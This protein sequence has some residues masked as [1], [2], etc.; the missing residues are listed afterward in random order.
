MFGAEYAQ[1]QHRIPQRNG[2]KLAS[3]LV[4]H[5]NVHGDQPPYS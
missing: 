3:M 2:A 4:S 1:K 5:A